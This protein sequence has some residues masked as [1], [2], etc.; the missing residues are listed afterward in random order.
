MVLLS[1]ASAEQQLLVR[2]VCRA[3]AVPGE[4]FSQTTF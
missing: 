2:C 4:C 1:D 3:T